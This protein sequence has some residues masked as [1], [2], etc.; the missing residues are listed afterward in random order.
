MARKRSE[1]IQSPWLTIPEAATYCRQ[2]YKE[3]KQLVDTGKIESHRRGPHSVF[4]EI[5]ILNAYMRSLPSGAKV[6]AIL[7][8]A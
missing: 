5:P 6:P 7:Q 8:D 4:L 2:D 3:F 1:P